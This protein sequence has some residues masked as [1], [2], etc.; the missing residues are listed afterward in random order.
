MAETSE[1]GWT[2]ATF[3][4]WWG[5]AHVSPGCARCFA[6][7][8]AKRYG[9][10]VWGK[11]TERRMFGEAHW[12]QPLSWDRKAARDGRRLK[13]FCASMADVFEDRPDLEAPRRRLWSLIAETPNLDWQL[14]T[15]RP[16]NVSRMV[17]WGASWDSEWPRNAW[18]GTSVED[19]QRADERIPILLDIPAAIRFLSVEPL[20]GPIVPRVSWFG[21]QLGVDWVIIGGESGPGYRPMDPKWLSDMARL[22]AIYVPVFVKQDSGSRPGRQGRIPADLW[23]LKELPE[24]PATR[25]GTLLG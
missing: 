13:V 8:L 24:S 9:H 7:T 10:Q 3:N 25:L 16:E 4:P 20:I 18:V 1:I 6:E 17:P 23:A 2:D 12:R 19:Q 11:R 5:C 21:S 14:L 15:K 22:A